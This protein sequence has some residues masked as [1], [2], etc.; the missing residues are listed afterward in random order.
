MK[1]LFFVFALMLLCGMQGFALEKTVKLTVKGKSRS[2]LLHAPNNVKENAPLV[3]SLHGTG[4]HSSDKAPMGTDVADANGFIVVYPQG[5][6]IYFPVFGGTLPGW[7]STGEYS[8]DIDFFKAIIEDVEKTYTIDH[9]RIYCCGFSNGGMMTYSQTN[10]S[11]DIFAAYASISGF[12]LNEFHLH[13]TGVRPIPFLHIHGK[14]DNFVDIARMPTI[15][16]EMVARIGANPVPVVTKEAGKYTKSVYEATEGGFPYIYYVIEGMGHEA[17][18]NKTPEGHSGKT[19]WNFMKQYTLDSPRDETLKWRPNVETEGYIPSQHG[20]IITGKSMLYGD[21]PS[22]KYDKDN[23]PNGKN[24]QNVYHSLQLTKGNY[25]L[26]FNS[27]G[28]EGTITVSIKKYTGNKAEIMKQTVAIGED[29]T[30]VFACDDDFAECRFKLN[31]TTDVTITDIALYTATD[32]EMSSVQ[33][34]NASQNQ[35]T[36]YYTLAGVPVS[37]P[38]KGYNVVRT[39]LDAK[40]IYVK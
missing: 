40:T 10:T 18:T 17:Y 22:D 35:T 37:Q 20:W 15:V 31:A 30:M 2:Y 4:G 24:I 5:S 21:N 33:V 34:P 7:N 29:A 39:G 9:K 26:W 1:K 13:H 25:K 12:Q 27:K 8:E 23:N 3:F 28:A 6:D 36:A 32:E 11:A 14:N 16:D 38:Q 19:M